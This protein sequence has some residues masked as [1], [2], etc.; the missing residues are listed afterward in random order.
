[1]AALEADASD[2][3][4]LDL[5]QL[6]IT[7]DDFDFDDN[8]EDHLQDEIV[9]EAL[10]QGLDLRAHARQVERDLDSTIRESI[11]DYLSEALRMT[12]LYHQVQ[13]C[14]NI[15]SSM[16]NM[17]CEFQTNLGDIS[18][19]IQSLQGQSV[20]M[21]IRLK[22]RRQVQQ[23]LSEL[24][25]RL[26]L[27]SDIIDSIMSPTVGPDFEEAVK[28]LHRKLVFVEERGGNLAAVGDVQGDLEQLSLQAAAKIRE[29]FMNT[30]MR[31]RKPGRDP[32]LIL[33][34]WRDNGGPTQMPQETLLKNKACFEF[35][36][37]H[38]RPTA[39]ELRA[40]YVNTMSKVHASYVKAD[41]QRLL[42]M[43]ISDNSS[44]DLLG[45]EAG[46]KRSGFFSSKP[47][48]KAKQTTFTLGSRAK[49][50]ERL[51]DTILLSQ[52]TEVQADKQQPLAY[53]DIFRSYQLAMADIGAREFLFCTEFFSVKEAKGYE[54][55]KEVMG[56]AM[57]FILKHL[58]THLA[59]SFDAIGIAL[60][61]RINTHYR[62]YV[63]DK[64]VKA[65]KSYFDTT[66]KLLWTNFE[67]IIK[68]HLESV[69]TVDPSRL[70]DIDTRPHYIVR[71][72]AE[73]S[74]A[75]IQ[76]KQ[77]H[78]FP[79][80]DKC[81]KQLQHEVMNLILRIAAEFT[82]RKDQL[83]FL[84]NNYDMMLSVYS[85]VTTQASQEA[86][87]T[88]A[89]LQARIQ[90]YALVELSPGFG[91]LIGFVKQAEASLATGRAEALAQNTGKIQG[92]IDSFASN[93]RDHINTI[94]GGVMRSFTNFENGTAILQ[95]ALTQLVVYYEKFTAIL[96]KAPFAQASSWK[97]LV[98]RHQLMVEVKK[99]KTTF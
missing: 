31:A 91:G 72:Y 74:G 22:N 96:K 33:T 58:E 15:L 9:Q 27:P 19:E 97:N 42:K 87:D 64:G 26:A 66:E 4:Q 34:F 29:L 30:I 32:Q 60:C 53:E 83:V 8:I 24:I 56:K 51:D 65:L 77:G 93:W 36:L 47:S 3:L 16:E 71:R 75:M 98:D 6:D 59:A 90:E 37:K 46:T 81:L 86:A 54:F 44:Q 89:A 14:D 48:T 76:L 88:Q 92:L 80:L 18:G 21:S 13:S 43:Q 84:I 94:N 39:N 49:V 41:V 28:E 11:Q 17:L 5:T 73:F 63:S 61:A 2:E 45:A 85:G 62:H 57:G 99:H 68:A 78:E 79:V 10:D 40:E 50:L 82:D 23:P 12:E 95:E 38:H 67:R 55:F 25:G 20:D 35:M 52:N 1:M 70:R 7:G 69:L